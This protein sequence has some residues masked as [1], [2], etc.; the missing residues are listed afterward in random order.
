MGL[1]DLE[2]MPLMETVSSSN[3]EI[4]VIHLK[5]FNISNE[6]QSEW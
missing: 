5:Q 4:S 2:E 1:G 6:N 3:D